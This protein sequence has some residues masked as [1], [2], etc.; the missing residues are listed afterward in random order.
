MVSL[1]LLALCFL[2]RLSLAMT[3]GAGVLGDHQVLPSLWLMP[4]R[5]LIAT[6]LWIGGFASNTVVWRGERFEVRK[7]KLHPA[8]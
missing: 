3:V 6:G 1:W 2:L 8:A 4:V 5:D 7:G